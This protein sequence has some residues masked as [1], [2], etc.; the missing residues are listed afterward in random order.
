MPSGRRRGSSLFLLILLGLAHQVIE[1]SSNSESSGDASEELF[2]REYLER[3]RSRRQT[4]SIASNMSDGSDSNAE[5]DYEYGDGFNTE[6]EISFSQSTHFDTEHELGPEAESR[7]NSQA[8]VTTSRSAPS[9]APF[10]D[11]EIADLFE[12]GQVCPHAHYFSGQPNEY[13]DFCRTYD[14]PDDVVISQVASNKI[15]DKKEH[16]PEHITVPLMAICEAGLR[17][18]LHPFLREL[19]AK[20]GLVPH[21]FAINSYRIVMSVIKL[22]ELH[23]LE[24][25]ISD[26]FHTYVMSRHGKTNRRYLSI[27]S[28]KEPLKDGLP[29]TDKW[30]NFYVE[31]SGNYE[32]G[33]Q[34]VRLHS[35]PKITDFRDHQS[36]TKRQ[37]YLAVEKNVETLQAQVCRDVPTLLGYKPSYKGKLKRREK[38]AG[39][40]TTAK[41]DFWFQESQP[42]TASGLDVPPIGTL[43]PNF[44]GDMGRRN[45]IRMN[46][47][48]KALARQQEAAVAEHAAKKQ[49][50]TH[51]LFQTKPLMPTIRERTIPNHRALVARRPWRS[52][53]AWLIVQ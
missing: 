19:L 50:V 45:V 39:P 36:I 51:D 21:F 46:I 13:E 30:A 52:L 34:T 28:G 7:F 44:A 3:R 16:C 22:K 2:I 31:V 25:T 53:G 37:Q 17:F 12:K 26:L 27:R 1:I 38:G 41:A 33:D 11:R 4:S 18:P 43:I 5:R 10:E 23:D 40:S 6:P 32:F 15:R 20:F 42:S 8:E 35:V 9:E 24:F 49:K 14:I 29:D 48:D 47:K